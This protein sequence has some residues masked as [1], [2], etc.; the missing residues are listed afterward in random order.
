MPNTPALV[1]RAVTAIAPGNFVT[2]GDLSWAESLLS[3]I[4]IVLRL[5]EELLDEARVREFGFHGVFGLASGRA[6]ARCEP[7]ADLTTMLL[8]A[9]EY[10]RRVADRIARKS[11][12]DFEQFAQRLKEL[13][14]TR[15]N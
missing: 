2:E 12:A 5:P 10:G 1:G 8:A 13:P 6:A 9:V 3:G 15:E 14:D 7:G 11:G 4:G